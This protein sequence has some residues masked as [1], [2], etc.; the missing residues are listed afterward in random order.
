MTGK[1]NEREYAL[2]THLNVVPWARNKE[3]CEGGPERR[4][5]V[6]GRRQERKKKGERREK[7]VLHLGM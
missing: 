2:T 7:H 1:A 5:I 3:Y 4:D 6:A